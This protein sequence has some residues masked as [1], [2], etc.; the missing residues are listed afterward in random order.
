MQLRVSCRL[1][2]IVKIC[3]KYSSCN[4]STADNILS[5]LFLKTNAKLRF[6][7]MLVWQ[8]A[9]S[10]ALYFSYCQWV[11][12]AV[13]VILV[14]DLLVFLCVLR[15]CCSHRFFHLKKNTQFPSVF[16]ITGAGCVCGI[17]SVHAKALGIKKIP[18]S[19]NW[20]LT[21]KC[22][23]QWLKF[24]LTQSNRYTQLPLTLLY[25]P[26]QDPCSC[27]PPLLLAPACIR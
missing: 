21:E 27:L 10:G 22:M 11:G 16:K 5:Y 13:N 20:M 3:L 26:L 6:W 17:F 12:K 1:V 4:S 25:I 9:D 24:D 8:T 7:Q 19:E 18:Q 14:L 15:H 2:C 23:L